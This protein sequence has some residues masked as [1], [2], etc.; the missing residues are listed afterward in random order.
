MK[1]I[2]QAT[3]LFLLDEAQN[4]IL[5]GHKKTGIGKGKIL[6]IGGHIEAGE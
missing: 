2:V 5:L 4:R 3:E 6:G 1:S